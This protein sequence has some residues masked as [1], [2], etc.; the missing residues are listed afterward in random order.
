MS[1]FGQNET[2]CLVGLASGLVRDQLDQAERLIS[3]PWTPRRSLL[4]D[5]A[6]F[7]ELQFHQVSARGTETP[8]ATY[9]PQLHVI[10]GAHR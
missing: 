3:K 1:I 5:R 2:D 8:A 6:Q 10:R 4:V 7:L 9:P